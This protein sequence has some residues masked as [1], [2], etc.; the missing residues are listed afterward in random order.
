M[1]DIDLG[2]DPEWYVFLEGGIIKESFASPEGAAR[3]AATHMKAGRKVGFGNNGRG[4]Q[5]IKRQDA[6]MKQ[7]ERFL[8]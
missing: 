7:L 6:F 3:V 5:V 4:E 1:P 2:P 8:Y